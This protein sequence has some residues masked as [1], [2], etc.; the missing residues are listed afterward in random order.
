[1]GRNSF[2]IEWYISVTMAIA[3]GYFIASIY[4]QTFE[5]FVILALV[6]V[7]LGAMAKAVLGIVYDRGRPG[8]S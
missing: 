2:R 4:H 5:P 1:M 3:L 7:I 6:V 8:S